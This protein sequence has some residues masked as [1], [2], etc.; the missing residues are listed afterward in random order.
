M[1][2]KRKVN[3]KKVIDFWKGNF[4]MKKVFIFLVSASP[5]MLFKCFV[6]LKFSKFLTNII[7]FFNPIPVKDNYIIRR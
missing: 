5:Q 4:F 3:E 1:K 2:A 7:Q 6:W